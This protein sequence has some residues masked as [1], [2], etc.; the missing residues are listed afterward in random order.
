[1][2]DSSQDLAQGRAA[3]QE[4]SQGPDARSGDARTRKFRQ[5]AFWYLHVGLL[6][7]GAVVAMWRNGLVNPIRGPIVLWLLLGAAIVALVFWGLWF[8]RSVWLAR[9]IWALHA[10]RLPSMI[11]GAF[12]PGP[13]A[14][15]P[16]A[17]YLTAIVVIVIN[18][19]MLARA[20]WDL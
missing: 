1:M 5:A 7:E 12:M 20:G 10:L 9:G 2:T 17:F 15:L 18:L 13:D 6:Y 8:R 19:W 14:A 4:Q 3:G 16:E 11:E